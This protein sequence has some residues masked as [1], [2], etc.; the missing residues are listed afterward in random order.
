[1]L[2]NA[3]KIGESLKSYKRSQTTQVSSDQNLTFHYKICCLVINRDPYKMEYIWVHIVDGRNPKQPPGMYKN[4]VNNGIF[5]ISTGERR[6]FEPSTV[7]YSLYNPHQPGSSGSKPSTTLAAPTRPGRKR[8]GKHQPGS[9]KTSTKNWKEGLAPKW[10][11]QIGVYLQNLGRNGVEGKRGITY[12]TLGERVL[13]VGSWKPFRIWNSSFLGDIVISGGLRGMNLEPRVLMMI[14]SIQP[15]WREN[16]HI[17]TSRCAQKR[18]FGNTNQGYSL[19][20]DVC[21]VSIRK[22]DNIAM[23]LGQT[24]QTWHNFA[25]DPLLIWMVLS[26]LSPPNSPSSPSWNSC[27][28]CSS[29]C[30][31][32]NFSRR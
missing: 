24:T 31:P 11:G 28:R 6:I 19:R 20:I 26:P 32:W 2:Q 27:F 14:Y 12:K 18:C 23:I 8:H 16:K 10:R 5:T 17:F 13:E 3:P 29:S 15:L 9:M 7:V 22:L 21:C 30:P 4:P 1:M 25:F